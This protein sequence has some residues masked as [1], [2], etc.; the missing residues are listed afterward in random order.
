M[1]GIDTAALRRM[2]RFGPGDFQTLRSAADEIDE[3][4]TEN[5]TLRVERDRGWERAESAEKEIRG[6]AAAL[7]HNT[8]RARKAEARLATV[9][10]LLA[11]WRTW[12]HD[13]KKVRVSDVLQVAADEL[14]AALNGDTDG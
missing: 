4:R 3:L 14:E 11:D 9:E 5:A 6:C 7:V 2:N 13:N 1:T 12:T 8:E 10:A